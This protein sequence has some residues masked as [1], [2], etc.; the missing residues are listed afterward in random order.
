M[1]LK[2]NIE[3][4]TSWGEEL[5]IC[6][7]AK[8][9]PLMHSGDGLW[10]GEIARI[11]LKKETEYSYEVVRDSQTIRTEWKGHVLTLPEGASPKVVDTKRL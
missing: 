11:S 2:V 1:K 6:I 7:G 3:Y 4:H 8:R 9:H 5:V 10:R